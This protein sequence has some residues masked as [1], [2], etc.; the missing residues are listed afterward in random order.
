MLES[1]ERPRLNHDNQASPE[2]N[3]AVL[4]LPLRQNALEE[5]SPPI[6]AQITAQEKVQRHHLEPES[7]MTNARKAWNRLLDNANRNDAFQVPDGNR[8]INLSLENQRDNEAW[9]DRLQE[10]P[11]GITRL[12]ALNLNGLSLDQR[13]GQFDD[14]CKIGKEVQ[15]DFICCQEPNVD[16]V[17][18]RVRTI[19]YQTARQHWNRSK[20]SVGTTPTPFISMYKPGGTLVLSTGNVTGRM[21]STETDK[22]G[23]W[24]SQSFRGHGNRT[25]T[26]ISAYQVMADDPEKGVISAAVQQRSLLLQTQDPLTDPRLA[27]K[28]DLTSYLERCTLN[29]EEIILVGD[30]NEHAT[31]VIETIASEFGLI[32]MMSLKHHLPPPVTYARGR[33]CLDLGFASPTVAQALMHCGY[34]QFHARFHTDHRA[35][36]FDFDT[37]QLFGSV[38]PSL[39][40]SS[41]RV[42]QSTNVA[43]VTRYMKEKYDYLL[44]CNA[45]ERAAQLTLP[46]NR[47]QFAERLDRDIVQASL[48]AEQRV[49]RIGEPAWSVA[50]DQARKRVMILKKCLSMA[51]TRLNLTTTIATSNAA[52]DYSIELPSNKRECSI[53]LRDAKRGER[54]SEEQPETKGS[55]A[56]R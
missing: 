12:Y 27:F 45:F 55:R 38:H 40:N 42:L 32:N 31:H 37:A 2:Q 53:R 7:P 11:T 17:Q 26:V 10:K 3:E 21:I 20:L 14:L 6:V 47:H 30:F 33:H 4:P 48:V 9:G 24:T 34:E 15:A 56:Q 1:N 25:I 13:G 39:A 16:A 51:R 23:R 28:R 41:Q 8:P 43:L 46:G 44:R 35:Y 36:F 5:A 54:P 18:P 52:L 29:D 50:L 22:W 19:L 49:Q